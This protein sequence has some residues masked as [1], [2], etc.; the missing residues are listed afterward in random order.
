MYSKEIKLWKYY[1]EKLLLAGLYVNVLNYASVMSVQLKF[2]F[3]LKKMNSE[4]HMVMKTSFINQG[5][6]ATYKRNSFNL[7]NKWELTNFSSTQ[8]LR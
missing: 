2:M 4:T 7:W 3:L 6:G 5:G 8:G 1:L